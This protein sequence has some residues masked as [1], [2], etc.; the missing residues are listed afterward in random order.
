MI[1][2]DW[3]KA[4]L[5]VSHYPTSTYNFVRTVGLICQAENCEIGALTSALIAYYATRLQ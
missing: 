4:Q 3:L 1:V 5:C 2:R